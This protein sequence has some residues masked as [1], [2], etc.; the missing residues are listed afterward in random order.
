MVEAVYFTDDDGKAINTHEPRLFTP[1]EES[2]MQLWKNVLND[3]DAIQMINISYD[4]FTKAEIL[5]EENSM[6]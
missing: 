2:V 3:D 1:E 6:L 5:T 4:M